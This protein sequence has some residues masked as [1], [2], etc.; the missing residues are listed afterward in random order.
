MWSVAYI[1]LLEWLWFE[2]MP[3]IKTIVITTTTTTIISSSSSI[4]DSLSF[5]D[6]V[7]L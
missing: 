3:S 1:Q 6:K 4:S 2:V 5:I 7:Y